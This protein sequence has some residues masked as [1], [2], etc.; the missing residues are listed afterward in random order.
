MCGSER[1]K[2]G[3]G[4][5]TEHQGHSAPL[6]TY[7][8]LEPDDA[9]E[10]DTAQLEQIYAR[11]PRGAML[12]AGIATAVVFALWAGFYLFVFIPRGFLR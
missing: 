12:V 1:K 8:M 7:G 6:D 9:F 2:P 11:A 3:G 10:P 5:H 4:A